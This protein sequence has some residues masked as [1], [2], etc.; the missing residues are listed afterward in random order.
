MKEGRDHKKVASIMLKIGYVI[1][2]NMG[3]NKYAPICASQHPYGF[4]SRLKLE[5]RERKNS[6]KASTTLVNY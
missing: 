6:I 4:K 1:V 3:I 5:I 2:K